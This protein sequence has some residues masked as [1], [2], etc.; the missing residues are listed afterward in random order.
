M[1]HE[2]LRSY[3]KRI[4]QQNKELPFID[5]LN[6]AKGCPMELPQIL[7]GERDDVMLTIAKLRNKAETSEK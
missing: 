4:I 3:A 5:I 7:N 2:Y 6:C 1:R